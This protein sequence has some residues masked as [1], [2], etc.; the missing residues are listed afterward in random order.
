MCMYVKTSRVYK[1]V[2]ETLDNK[3]EATRLPLY[4]VVIAY[5]SG[6]NNPYEYYSCKSIENNQ[7]VSKY[8][9]SPVV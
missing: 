1:A 4:R 8:S 6:M 2:C 5:Q 9:M 3:L 7:E